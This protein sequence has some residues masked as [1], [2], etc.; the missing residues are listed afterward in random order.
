L[1][2]E[3]VFRQ[4]PHRGDVSLAAAD[5]DNGASRPEQRGEKILELTVTTITPSDAQLAPAR[6][7]AA[8]P[9]APAPMMTTSTS[10]EAGT[11][12]SAGAAASAAEAA[13]K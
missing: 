8:M 7:A 2:V 11:A 6:R 13:R 4:S 5:L 9:A 12:P 1:P 3:Q 10:P